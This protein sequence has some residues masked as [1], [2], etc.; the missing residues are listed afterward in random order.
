MD[1]NPQIEQ[2]ERYLS[3]TIS[4]QEKTNLEQALQE[5]QDLATEF[6][7]RQRAHKLLDFAVVSNLKAQLE[8]LEEESKV[9]SIS[10]GRRKRLYTLS[11]A[12]SLLVLVGAFAILMPRNNLSSTEMAAAY[13][14][15]ADLNSQRSGETLET[16]PENYT[17]GLEA[18]EQ[19]QI[20]EAITA[21]SSVA[22]STGYAL[23]AQYFLAHALY[24]NQDYAQAA[25]N[26]GAVQA[27]GDLRF[28]ENAEWYGLLA[29][30]AQDGTCLDQAQQISTNNQH[31]FQQEAK[32][33][34]KRLK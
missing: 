25:E 22:D 8:S 32:K 19:N 11:I 18:L 13:Y 5:D 1:N 3:N 17:A 30:L 23:P 16:I 31:S 24:Q 34:V 9:V 4:A 14:S 15:G 10:Q 27:S 21:L 28:S 12:A 2:I 26:F 7:K 29:C 6:E 20:Q 33:I